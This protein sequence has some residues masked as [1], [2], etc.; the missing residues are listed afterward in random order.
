MEW[1]RIGPQVTNNISTMW[2]SMI[3]AYDIIRKWL[4]WH[5]R[6]GKSIKIGT[7]QWIGYS[8]DHRLH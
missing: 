5:A 8:G 1:I 4:I 2:K 7:N 3:Y 6:D